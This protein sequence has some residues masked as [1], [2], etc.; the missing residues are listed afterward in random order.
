MPKGNPQMEKTLFPS[1][2]EKENERI[3]KTF[4]EFYEK[5]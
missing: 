5:T 1:K 3:R 4:P 2:M